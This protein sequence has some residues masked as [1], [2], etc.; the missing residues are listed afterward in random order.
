MHVI[1]L[2]SKSL[3]SKFYKKSPKKED[4]QELFIILLCDF[5][6]PVCGYINTCSLVNSTI[7]ILYYLNMPIATILEIC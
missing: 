3:Y 4:N 5:Y 2:D 6:L 1:M 7:T